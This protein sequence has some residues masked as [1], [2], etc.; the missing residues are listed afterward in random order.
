MEAD[1]KLV[2]VL[3]VIEENILHKI[4]CMECRCSGLLRRKMGK[5]ILVPQN[6]K[7]TRLYDEVGN[8]G[9]KPQ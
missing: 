7:S 5:T 2:K 9:L 1:D 4:K 3:T 6:S 8:F